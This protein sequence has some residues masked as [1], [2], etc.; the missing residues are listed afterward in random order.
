M[1][2]TTSP[3]V[4]LPT[5]QKRS[6]TAALAWRRF[7]R[8]KV[9]FAALIFIVL[10]VLMA[11]FAPYI[12]PYDPYFSDYS[13]TY[14]PPSAKH[15]M[16]VD[17]LGRDVLSRVIFGARVS[18]AVGVIS[19]VALILIGMP[20]G[21]L[22]A[23]W[24]GWFDYALTRLIDILSSIPGFLLYILL[25]VAIG[26]GLGSIIIAMS[27]TG[28]IGIARL[29]RGQ[30][31]TLKESDF[32]RASRSM[33]A[34]TGWILQ[35][36]IVRNTLTPIIVSM[37]LGV[38]GA[39]FAEAGLSFLGLGIAAPTPSWGQMIGVYAGFVRTAPHLVVFPSLVLAA[40]ML[41]WILLGDGVRDALDPNIRS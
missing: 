28:W 1:A 36:H 16:G 17:D 3:A 23:L 9:A 7:A 38:P 37:T 27:V 18:Y 25:L 26:A 5:A 24:G 4:P 34:G 14:A 22:A 15:L 20:L 8:N 21:A 6:S 33:G 2:V 41:A 30:V 40:T 32:V 35:N 10:Q 11:V 13:V 19:Q 31:L 29:I 12:A 39:M